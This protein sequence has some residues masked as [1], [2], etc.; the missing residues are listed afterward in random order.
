M[1][2]THAF[3]TICVW[4]S[5][6]SLALFEEWSSWWSSDFADMVH[7]TASVCPFP[8]PSEEPRWPCD[9]H[10]TAEKTLYTDCITL[11]HTEERWQDVVWRPKMDSHHPG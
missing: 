11:P 2:F 3:D 4:G 1:L 10:N 6:T 5:E 7:F 9:A 8:Q